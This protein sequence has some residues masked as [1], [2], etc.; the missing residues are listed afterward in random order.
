MEKRGLQ[1]QVKVFK[2]KD[3][4]YNGDRVNQLFWMRII[5]QSHPCAVCDI[6]AG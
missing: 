2:I 3:L 5:K 1:Y 4:C 6:E